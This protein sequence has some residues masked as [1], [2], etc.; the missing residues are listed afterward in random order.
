METNSSPLRTISVKGMRKDLHTPEDKAAFLYPRRGTLTVFADRLDFDSITIALSSITHATIIAPYSRLLPLYALYIETADA[1]W[2]FGPHRRSVLDI[3][4]PFAV[5]RRW[6]PTWTIWL[7][8]AAGLCTLI[9]AV[10]R[11]IRTEY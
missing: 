7:W 6:G 10:L 1:T 2:I 5:S 3:D 9:W 4:Y 8:A 11:V